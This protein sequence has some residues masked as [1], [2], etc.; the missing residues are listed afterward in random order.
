MQRWMPYRLPDLLTA[1]MMTMTY[2]LFKSQDVKSKCS[3]LALF[4]IKSAIFVMVSF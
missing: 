4:L 1:S 3:S 2:S